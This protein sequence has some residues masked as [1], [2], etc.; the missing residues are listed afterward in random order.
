MGVKLSVTRKLLNAAP[1]FSSLF[2]FF[3][4]FSEPFYLLLNSLIFFFTRTYISFWFFFVI[5]S[6]KFVIISYLLDFSKKGM[7]YPSIGLSIPN[8]LVSLY[9]FWAS[10]VAAFHSHGLTN[11]NSLVF[12]VFLLTSFYHLLHFP[13]NFLYPIFLML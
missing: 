9:F 11:L 5:N 8:S 12:P 10:Q 4:S 2:S 1:L 6:I 7:F 13:L 3:A